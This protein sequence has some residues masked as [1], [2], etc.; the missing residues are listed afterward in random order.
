M[1]VADFGKKVN[2]VKA[3][4]SL[5]LQYLYFLNFILYVCMGVG[6]CSPHLGQATAWY[7]ADDYWSENIVV[8]VV[9][10]VDD[11]WHWLMD[12]LMDGWRNTWL[13]N[14]YLIA[15]NT[16]NYISSEKRRLV[17][18]TTKKTRKQKWWTRYQTNNV[19]FSLHKYQHSSLNWIQT[20]T[21]YTK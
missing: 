4:I 8:F 20:C 17:E 1:T 5:S 18:R 12:K 11:L 13:I 9:E 15:E 3:F 19:K 14:Q 6:I 7:T 21:S 10:A 16:Y 2:H